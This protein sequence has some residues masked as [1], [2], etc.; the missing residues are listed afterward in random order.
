[1]GNL[2]AKLGEYGLAGLVIAF[3]F[4][5]LWKLLTWVMKWVDKQ[6]ESHRVERESFLKRLES[7]DKNIDLHCQNSIEARKATEEAHRYQREEH[8]EMVSNLGEITKTLGRING[9]KG[10]S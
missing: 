5:V 9:Y 3:L 7:L 6:E 4:F 1:M 8:K 10:N 2:W